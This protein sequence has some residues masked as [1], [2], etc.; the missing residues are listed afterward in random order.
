[1]NNKE[2][3]NQFLS[4]IT[5]IG[6]LR[7]AGMALAFATNILLARLL[8]VK[9][10]GTVVY[11]LAWVGILS[12]VGVFGLDRLLVREIATYRVQSSWGLLRGVLRW[13]IAVSLL[14]SSSI[15]CIA[16]LIHPHIADS[17][18]N[19]VLPA[20]CCLLI[21]I[22]L[23]RVMGAALQGFHKV[24]LSQFAESFIQPGLILLLIATTGI[25]LKNNLT[26]G[27]ILYFYIIAAG[28]ACLFAGWMLRWIM[29]H[30]PKPKTPVQYSSKL[31]LIGTLPL[32]AVSA[33]DVLNTQLSSLMLGT[34]SGTTAV[35]VYAAAE[36]GAML[37]VLPLNVVSLTVA[38]TFAMLY[39][40]RE[41][42]NLQRLVT[43]SARFI[44]AVSTPVAL[45][46]IAGGQWFLMV[47]GQSFTAGQLPLAVL[48]IAQL[49]NAAIGP[50][51][52][53]L[54]MTGHGREA[55]VGIGTGVV[56]NLT[57]N[58]FLI[59]KWGAS[60][61]AIAAASSLIAWNIMLAAFVWRR[62][63]IVMTAF[64][65]TK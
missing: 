43:K 51:S 25:I 64:A 27:H 31:W 29:A 41:H 48:C 7:I 39:Q 23:T 28:T 16:I 22:V 38:P 45:A 37:V 50:V 55:A 56:L 11:V 33:L 4:S 24:V 18:L 13:G 32:F 63:G 58:L 62:L 8:G 60:G 59:P 6:G 26:A 46:L 5:G 3:A 35:G 10:Y 49:V 2:A 61:A 42:T 65:R 17:K 9:E 20:A 52:F 19:P 40:S 36:R 14:I 57:L 53:L 30:V 54:I 12:V 34:L 1:M 21:F 15:A 44:L 47:F